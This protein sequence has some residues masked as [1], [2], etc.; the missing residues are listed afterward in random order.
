LY[1]DARIDRLLFAIKRPFSYRIKQFLI[2]AHSPL[3][4]KLTINQRPGISTFRYW[5]E[6]PGYDRNL[7]NAF[8]VQSAIDYIHLN[9]VRRGLCNSA[10]DWLWSSARWY[11][12][13]TQLHDSRLPTLTRLPSEFFD[14]QATSSS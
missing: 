3:L 14:G 1:A 4:E 13:D 6:G 8:A 2:E 10:I 11:L 9:P 5:Q 7:M 12:S